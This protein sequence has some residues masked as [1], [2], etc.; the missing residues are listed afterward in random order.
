[1]LTDEGDSVELGKSPGY[2]MVTDDH[3]EITRQFSGALAVQQVGKA[4]LTGGNQD[5]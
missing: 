5:G 2:G 4:M 1:L 3:D